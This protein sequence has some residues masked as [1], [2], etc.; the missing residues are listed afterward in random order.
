[1]EVPL[2]KELMNNSSDIKS[3]INC[4][5]S[6]YK[7]YVDWVFNLKGVNRIYIYDKETPQNKYNIPVNKGQEAS[8]YLKYIVDNYNNLADYTFFSH[9]DEF[10]WHHSGSM[11]QKYNEACYEVFVNKKL[12]Y[13]VNDKIILGSI[14]NNPWYQ[15]ILIWYNEYIEKYIPMES[16]PKKDWTVGYRGSAQFIVHKSLIKNFPVEFYENLYKWIITTELSN[17]ETSRYMEWIWHLFWDIYP[18]HIKI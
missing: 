6:R 8:V 13:N 2:I 11:V 4:V 5:V 16:L 7:K 1:M 10:A 15:N 17:Y 14:V 18:K 9:D 3:T 12:F